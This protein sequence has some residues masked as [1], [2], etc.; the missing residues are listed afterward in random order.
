MAYQA[1][2]RCDWPP[3]VHL[4][5]QCTDEGERSGQSLSTPIFHRLPEVVSDVSTSFRNFDT[6]RNFPV[7]ARG[8]RHDRAQATW[9][10]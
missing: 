8:Q 7:L 6:P 9:Q 3:F 4:R 5:V 1:L 2:L 10:S